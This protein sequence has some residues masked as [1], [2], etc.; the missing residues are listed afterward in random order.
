MKGAHQPA[1][2]T[3]G[4]FLIALR[5]A[6]A[7]LVLGVLVHFLPL[8]TLRTAVTKIPPARFL[9]ILFLY[10]C[11]HCIG[12][13]KWRMVVNAAGSALDLAT[14]A[15][16]YFGGL[17]GTLFLPSIVGGDV[18][19]LAVGLRKSARPAAVLAGNLADRFLDVSAQAGLVVVGLFLL[20]GSLPQAWRERAIHY[21][22]FLIVAGPGLSSARLRDLSRSGQTQ[23][24]EIAAAHC[25]IAPRAAICKAPSRYSNRRLAYWN[26]HPIHIPRTH[27]PACYFLWAHASSPR[28]AL[29]LAARQARGRSSA[30][31]RRHRS[32]RSSARRTPRAVRRA[33]RTC[34]RCW[35]GLG[36]NHNRWGPSVRSVRPD[37]WKILIFRKNESALGTIS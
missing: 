26:T 12:V 29:R 25:A 18:I 21:L 22:L 32:S 10:L 36:R 24:V 28:L 33:G 23:L 27:C 1:A 6:A 4:W 5:W 9:I 13:L 30:H 20:P 34:F 14:S 31:A 17:F 15:Q 37:T 7:L 3:R 8:A 19:R 11:A 35:I 16:C 2:S